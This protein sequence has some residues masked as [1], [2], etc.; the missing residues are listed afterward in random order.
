MCGTAVEGREE[1]ETR[2][3]WET[4]TQNECVSESVCSFCCTCKET[5]D[6]SIMENS[7][8]EKSVCRLPTAPSRVCFFFGEVK[9]NQNNEK[10]AG[11]KLCHCVSVC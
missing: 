8:R 7:H 4:H 10:G 3:G 11:K 6:E 5:E 2:T 9:K 1:G